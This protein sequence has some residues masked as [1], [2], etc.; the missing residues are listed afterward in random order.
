MLLDG[1]PKNSSTINKF[2][3]AAHNTFDAPYFFIDVCRSRVNKLLVH[4]GEIPKLLQKRSVAHPNLI[5]A[6]L[7]KSQFIV[8]C[9]GAWL[10]QLTLAAH[11]RVARQAN[12]SW[13][14]IEVWA[15]DANL[16]A[17][18]LR[19][20]VDVIFVN[21]GSLKAAAHSFFECLELFI[22]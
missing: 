9:L 3:I 2:W 13:S 12:L 4:R 10:L 14:F 20:L 22:E 1:P 6:G 11:C 8:F 15:K 18:M 21:N 16:R 5:F 7:H 19:S 17:L